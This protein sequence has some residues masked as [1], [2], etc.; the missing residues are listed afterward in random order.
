[1]INVCGKPFLEH[2][3]LFLK[4][5]ILARYFLYLDIKNKSISNY[6]GDGKKW[7]LSFSYNITPDHYQTGL[8]IK[9]ATSQIEDII[10]FFTLL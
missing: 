8:K 10:F 7:D 5:I 2:L 6:F 9:R 1:M 4:K 3:V